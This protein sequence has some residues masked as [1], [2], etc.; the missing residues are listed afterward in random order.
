VCEGSLVCGWESWP[1]GAG[2]DREQWHSQGLAALVRKEQLGQ[3]Y[4]ATAT[5]KATITIFE[6][7]LAC[8]LLEF[9]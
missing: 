3:L 9:L 7:Q 6:I 1:G 8:A 5:V 2:S 4:G